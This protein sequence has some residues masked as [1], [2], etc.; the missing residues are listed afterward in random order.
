MER[1]ID[2]RKL[3]LIRR[4]SFLI[5]SYMAGHGRLNCHPGCCFCEV[6]DEF[7]HM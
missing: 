6:H 1:L 2:A 4:S 5:A 3:Y 7:H